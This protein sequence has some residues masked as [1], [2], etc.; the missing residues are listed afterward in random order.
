MR[1][2]RFL[3][4]DRAFRTEIAAARRPACF[5]EHRRCGRRTIHQLTGHLTGDSSLIIEALPELDDTARELE[6]PFADVMTGIVV[7]A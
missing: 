1:H 6:R 7:C 4:T 5:L 2:A 3:Q